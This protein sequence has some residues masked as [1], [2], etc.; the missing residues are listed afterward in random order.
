MKNL[1]DS[2]FHLWS[3]LSKKRK[4]LPAVTTV[5]ILILIL[6]C[7]FLLFTELEYL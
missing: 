5:Y 1:Q 6:D 2:G 7:I 3:F 4:N